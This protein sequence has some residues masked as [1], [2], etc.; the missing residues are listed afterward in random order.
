MNVNLVVGENYN[1]ILLENNIEN[2]SDI[3]FRILSE[4]YGLETKVVN[5][6]STQLSDSLFKNEDG[7]YIKSICISYR[8]LEDTF[9][10]ECS[11][12]N[13]VKSIIMEGSNLI[14]N[15]ISDSLIPNNTRILTDS[16]FIGASLYNNNDAWTF[17]SDADNICNVFQIL[18]FQRIH[19]LIKLL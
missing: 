18:Q 7:S 17:N 16:V 12:L 14:I 2:S 8:N 3:N 10:I 9:L 4:F 11:E 1:T 5:L 6:Y 15:D 13:V 19:C